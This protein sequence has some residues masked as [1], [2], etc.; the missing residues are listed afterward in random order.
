MTDTDG[1]LAV[2]GQP[3][4]IPSGLQHGTDLFFEAFEADLGPVVEVEN[5]LAAWDQYY[6]HG[7]EPP[8]SFNLQGLG[9]LPPG[10]VLELS[11]QATFGPADSLIAGY[12]CN[13]VADSQSGEYLIGREV[14][15]NFPSEGPFTGLQGVRL[16]PLDPSRRLTDSGPVD[17]WWPSTSCSGN[18]STQRLRSSRPSQRPPLGTRSCR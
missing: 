14:M 16:F 7:G 4:P 1:D 5:W 3:A 9:P 18:V 12:V 2:D 11:G 8:R 6:A 15:V 17:I 13:V 10:T